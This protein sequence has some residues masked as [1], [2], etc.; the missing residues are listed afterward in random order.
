MIGKRVSA[1]VSSGRLVPDRLV[2]EV[3]AARLTRSVLR[4]G[5]VLDGFPRT[6]GQAQGLDR[7]L[8]RRSAPLDGAVYLTSPQDL[9]VRRLSG[10]RVCETCGDIYHIRTMRPKHPGRCDRCHG[11]LGIRTD[12]TPAT[13]RKRLALDRQA[14]SPLLQHYERQGI[15]HRVNGAGHVD[16]AFERLAR[17]MRREGWIRT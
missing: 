2:V 3:M 12:D 8:G 17:L 15:L 5:F 10:R 11:R 9:L 16:R 7:V 6:R 14:V 1:Y 13:I 4:T